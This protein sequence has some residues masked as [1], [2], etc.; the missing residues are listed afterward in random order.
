MTVHLAKEWGDVIGSREMGLKFR[1]ILGEHA[2]PDSPVTVDLEGIEVLTN[3]FADEG[4]A[5][6]IADHGLECARRS[7]IFANG[8]AEVR[9]C[10]R[11]AI[12]NRLLNRS[13]GSDPGGSRYPMA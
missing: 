11:F 1:M 9:K 6:F 7:L 2:C 12:H 8:S 5:K 13:A 4:F 3:S 10:L